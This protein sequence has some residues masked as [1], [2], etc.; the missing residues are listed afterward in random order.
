MFGLFHASVGGLIAVERVLASTLLGLVLGWVCWTTQSVF[1]G[2][3]LH[4]LNNGLM[5]SLAYFGPELQAWGWDAEH[6]R[7]LPA[8]L[9]AT[10]T[11]VALVAL[12]PHS[13]P[14][15]AGTKPGPGRPA[16]RHCPIN[17]PYATQRITPYAATSPLVRSIAT[18]E[19]LLPPAPLPCRVN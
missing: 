16:N 13:Q 6:Q 15:L 17:R 1:P 10:T 8:P 2:M 14:P 11:V 18:H 5:L 9:V 3:V 12:A 4:A 7:Y 19:T